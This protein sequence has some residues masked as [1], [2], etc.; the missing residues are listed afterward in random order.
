M[1]TKH[2]TISGVKVILLADRGFA[3]QKFFRFLDEELEFNYIDSLDPGAALTESIEQVKKV[4]AFAS[5]R[6][7]L[8]HRAWCC[9]EPTASLKYRAVA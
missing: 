9:L 2:S 7:H 8:N 4:I 1:A 6:K 3:D 5:S